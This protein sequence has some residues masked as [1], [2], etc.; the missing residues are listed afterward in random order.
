MPARD[1]AWRLLCEYT[2]SESLRR[3][4]QAVEACLLAYA[5]KLGQDEMLWGLTGLLHD[6]DY[7]KWPNPEQS[8]AGGHPGEGAKILRERGY[9]EEM[10]HAILAHAGYTGVPRQSALDHALFACDELSGFL[11]ACA[12]VR[13]SKSIMEVEAASAVKK[14]KDKAFARG[15]SRADVYQGAQELDIALEDH[16]AFCIAALQAHAAE[17][18]LAGHCIG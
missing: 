6:F 13:P 15:V 14:L 1:D 7:E 18:G 2:S 4:A 10:I 5:R 16:I 8:A 12:L 11:T 17:L 3:H 9:P